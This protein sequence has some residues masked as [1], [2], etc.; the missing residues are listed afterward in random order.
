M[1]PLDTGPYRVVEK[2]SKE[3]V[4]VQ[5]LADKK[6]SKVHVHRVKKESCI[7]LG[8]AHNLGRTYPVHEDM[9]KDEEMDDVPGSKSVGNQRDLAAQKSNRGRRKDRCWNEG[10]CTYDLHSK[11]RVY[12]NG[13]CRKGGWF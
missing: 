5:R 7:R 4:K 13:S 8:Q 10:T 2:I 1:Q 12:R 3:V 9:M 11:G 6:V